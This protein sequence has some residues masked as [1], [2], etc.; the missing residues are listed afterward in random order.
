MMKAFLWLTLIVF[1]LGHQGFAQVNYHGSLQVVQLRPHT[2]N[3]QFTP[4]GL[5][6]WIQG[7]FDLQ[8]SGNRDWHAVFGFPR[9]GLRFN[10]MYLGE[11]FEQLGWAGSVIP[12]IDFGLKTFKK[13]ALRFVLGF[14]A[15]YH[16][17]IYDPI[18]NPLQNTISLKVNNQVS[19][20]VRYEKHYQNVGMLYTGLC[21]DHISNGGFQLPNLGLNYLGVSLG[22]RSEFSKTTVVCEAIKL[23][24]D[25]S[26]W[27]FGISTGMAYREFKLIGGPKFPVKIL[28]LELGYHYHPYKLI[29]FGIEAE[30]HRLA[31]YFAAHTEIKPDIHSAWALGTRLQ[32]F[33]GHEWLVG[34]LGLEARLGY[35][36]LQ[37]SLLSNVPLFTRLSLQ[38]YL[39]LPCIKDLWLAPGL[40]LKSHYATAEY[41]SAFVTLRYWKKGK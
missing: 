31:S 27:S 32:F 2:A 11:P 3:F 24:T 14:G 7:G 39:K 17:K 23:K 18:N 35:Q 16:S 22:W 36:V 21:M 38:Y 37:S 40:A 30:H 12:Y 10:A 9:F 6:L 15:S 8:T 34:N 26:R 20:Q 33:V 25:Y 1:I 19:F 13:S 4:N 5:G 41:M 28:S 29:R